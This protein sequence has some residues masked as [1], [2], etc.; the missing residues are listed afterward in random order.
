[1]MTVET[2]WNL[3]Q[4]GASDVFAWDQ[5]ED[6]AAVIVSRFER[7]EAVDDLV[8][9]SVVKENLVGQSATWISVLRRV[10]ELADC[11]RA[12]DATIEGE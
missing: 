9:S 12:W 4:A 11:E 5:L 6:P 10:V 7:W 1:M 3:L 2:I 8:H